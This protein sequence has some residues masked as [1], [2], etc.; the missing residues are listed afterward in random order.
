LEEFVL[1]RR[2]H[3]YA[4]LTKTL[5]LER[6]YSDPAGDPAAPF[7]YWA[8]PACDNVCIPNAGH[9]NDTPPLCR[10]HNP[11]VRMERRTHPGR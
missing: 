6:G 7:V 11:A 8:C 1:L 3:A 5:G 9:E 10:C 2:R 4:E